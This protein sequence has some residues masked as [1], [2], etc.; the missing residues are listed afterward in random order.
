MRWKE[1]QQFQQEYRNG[2]AGAGTFRKVPHPLL[3]QPG[4]AGAL[5]GRLC[6]LLW[7]LRLK[8]KGGV[9]T[10]YRALARMVVRHCC[11]DCA[12]RENKEAQKNKWAAFVKLQRLKSIGKRRVTIVR[13]R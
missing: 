8:D 3:W 13:V 6:G 5:G 9:E 4:G 12:N 10:S 1:G 7:M 11:A 2:M